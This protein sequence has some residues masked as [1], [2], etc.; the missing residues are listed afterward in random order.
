MCTGTT[1]ASAESTATNVLAMLTLAKTLL[2]C[3]GIRQA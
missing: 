1:H 3:E 2:V